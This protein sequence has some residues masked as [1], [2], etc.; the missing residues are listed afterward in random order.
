MYFRS[1]SLLATFACAGL[2]IAA[3]AAPVPAPAVP[4]VGAPALPNL[5]VPR[6]PV[7]TTVVTGALAN[8]EDVAKL[9]ALPVPRDVDHPTLPE[10]FK[11]IVIKVNPI[12]DKL[13]TAVSI[14]AEIDATVVV[15]LL[16]EIIDVLSV[17]VSEVQYIVD[18]PVDFVLSIDGVVLALD[19]V[20]AIVVTVLYV[21]FSTLRVVVSSV[22][23]TVHDA[24]LPLVANIGALVT[25]L[26]TLALTLVPGLLVLLA[27]AVGGLVD[28]LYFLNIAGVVHV[29]GLTRP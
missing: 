3:P 4:N 6:S 14:K 9:P 29:L 10:V 7:D 20:S 1:L 8:A 12:A 23:G 22:D 17:A 16:H 15:D 28:T 24:V 25:H 26:L 19:A 21:I 2:T 18:N 13:K 27:A 11:T 5:P